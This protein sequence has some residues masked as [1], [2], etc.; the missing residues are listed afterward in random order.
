MVEGLLLQLEYFVE[1]ALTIAFQ[2]Q[3]HVLEAQA[4]EDRREFSAHLQRQRALHL[5]GCDFDADYLAVETDAELA[6]AERLQLLLASLD[7]LHVLDGHRR[8]IR[9]ARAEAGGRRAIPG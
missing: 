4:L 5:I 9:Y 8:S 6:E 2:I 3:R 7:G 1:R